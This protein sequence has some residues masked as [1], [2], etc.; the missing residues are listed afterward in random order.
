[1]RCG[2]LAGAVTRSRASARCAAPRRHRILAVG[3]VLLALVQQARARADEAFERRRGERYIDALVSRFNRNLVSGTSSFEWVVEKTED[4]AGLPRSLRD[5]AARSYVQRFPGRNATAGHGPWRLTLESELVD[6]VSKYSPLR[7][8]E[9][10]QSRERLYLAFA[11]RCAAGGPADNREIVMR[12]LQARRDVAALEGHASFA[13][14]MMRRQML[15]S[16]AVVDTLL[17][18]LAEALR[19]LVQREVGALEALAASQGFLGRLQPWDLDY[20]EERLREVS[21]AVDEEALREYLALPRILDALFGLASRLFGLRVTHVAWPPELGGQT[22]AALYNVS[23]A[24]T[25]RL[26]G[27]FI[28]DPHG[29]D[30]STSTLVPRS[31]QTLPR[32][33]ISLR[34]P[35]PD[36]GEPC[37]LRLKNVESLFH[38]FGHA[39][40]TMCTDRFEFSQLERDN[41][42]VVSLFMECWMYHRPTFDAFAMHHRTGAPLPP[43]AFG[44]IVQGARLGSARLLLWY[45]ARAALDMELHARCPDPL[46]EH[47]LLEA[48]RRVLA[49]VA[50]VA[51]HGAECWTC[52]FD[53]IFD[54]DAY[55]ANEYAYVWGQVLAWDAFSAFEE[56]AAL[57][58]AAECPS[59]VEA[60][61]RRFRATVLGVDAAR[62]FLEVYREFRGRDPEIA[63]LLRHKTSIVVASPSQ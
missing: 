36:P 11:S 9:S 51:P 3:P 54:G 63:A 38:E 59:R 27:S 42:E 12:L 18:E 10:A 53:H 20:W 40:A 22:E 25:G 56:A 61:G 13:D 16:V 2:A 57:D 62:P 52:I 31:T 35:M 28:L 39:L 37:L 48:E 30:E 45:V 43:G 58:E 46:T 55:A 1:M 6:I 21:C 34:L 50:G 23:D 15:E 49:A 24:E 32:E 8:L 47:S 44:N 41:I 19:P 29:E 26:L 17:D 60:L 4:I 7:Y 5:A 33:L 14:A